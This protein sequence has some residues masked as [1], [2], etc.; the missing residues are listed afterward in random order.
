MVIW[1]RESM[2]DMEKRSNECSVSLEKMDGLHWG[3]RSGLI[4]IMWAPMTPD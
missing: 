4:G 2:R 1:E 3:K